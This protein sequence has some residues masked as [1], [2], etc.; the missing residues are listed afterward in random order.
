MSP[1][2]P[3]SLL[4]VCLAVLELGGAADGAVAR[5]N[6][7][8]AYVRADSAPSWIWV[9]RPD[10]G[11]RHA[12]VQG[13]QPAWSP[14]GSRLAFVRPSESLESGIYVMNADGSGLRLIAPRVATNPAWSPDSTRI[15]FSDGRDVYSIGAD[16]SRAEQL[17]ADPGNDTAPS[18]SPEGTRIAFERD[19]ALW[20][21]DADGGNERALGVRGHT[22]RFSPDGTR[23][24]FEREG[25]ISVMRADGTGPVQAVSPPERW[26]YGPA[27]APDGT[28]LAFDAG[29]EV[30]TARP[31]G[32][33]ARRVTYDNP[34]VSSGGSGPVLDWQPSASAASGDAL[35]SCASQSWDIELTVQTTRKRA[36][37]GDYVIFRIVE[38]NLGPDPA[39]ATS[40][41]V[42]WPQEASWAGISTQQGTCPVETGDT[43]PFVHCEPGVIF[44]GRSAVMTIELRMRGPGP[45]RVTA[46][47]DGFGEPRDVNAANDHDNATVIVGGCTITGTTGADVLTGT[48][49]RDVICG[50]DG[51]DVI[52][53]LGGNDEISGGP[54]DDLIEGGPGNDRM[55]GGNGADELDGG[56]GDDVAWG[57]A[58]SDSLR[59]GPG[60]DSLHGDEDLDRLAT[61][62]LAPNDADSL[63]GGPGA[64]VLDG[65]QGND[66]LRAGRGDDTVFAR[67][68]T[69]DRVDCGPGRDRLTADRVDRQQQCERISRP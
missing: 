10:G 52:R 32:T 18:W 59:G 62:P 48:P 26:S 27:W 40:F 4:V 45:Q 16:G 28:R 55:L 12:L 66:V 63:E 44:P 41:S 13:R 2:R 14:D 65:A 6:G 21:M 39:M 53:G 36:A 7:L 68:R 46:E 15:V 17:T 8:I 61:E 29:G 5:A 30:C 34:G 37:I 22:P 19:G 51:K 43:F 35:Y 47:M 57:A 33:D 24:A 1:L 25:V 56:A 3:L 69:T 23:V 11:G 58:G 54:R 31:D 38:R 42:V 9:V 50:L 20:V 67:D 60:N 49:R 64:D